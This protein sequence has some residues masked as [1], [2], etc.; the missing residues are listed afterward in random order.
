MI[1]YRLNNATKD[2]QK[3]EQL[4]MRPALLCHAI[5]L[6]SLIP[7]IAQQPA[8]TLEIQM[9]E[10]RFTA[11]NPIML[12]VIV[13][14]LSTENL[15]VWKA[16]PIV[17][18]EAEAY[19]FVEVRDAEGKVLPRIDGTTITLRDGRRYMRPKSWLTRKGATI[20]RHEELHD[21]LV[22]S[23]L[24]DLSKPGTYTA[25]VST[26]VEDRSGTEVKRARAV[27]NKVSFSVE[28]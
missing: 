21:F 1:R 5:V 4:E 20:K 16:D 7:C 8:A 2:R 14:N 17:D 11:G 6:F 23:N 13:K 15:D 25:S 18:G 9:P 3:K 24:F 22:L 10:S 19:T 27:S 26:D 12:D 28:Q